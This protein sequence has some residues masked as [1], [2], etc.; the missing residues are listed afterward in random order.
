MLTWTEMGEPHAHLP[1]M[2]GSEAAA[3]DCIEANMV[4]KVKAL[5]NKGWY[6]RRIAKHLGKD[7]KQV[8]LWYKYDI[9]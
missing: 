5:R 4:K 7:V 2:P 8:Y 3:A 6:F 9:D 1:L